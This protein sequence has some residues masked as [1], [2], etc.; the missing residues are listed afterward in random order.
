MLILIPGSALGYHKKSYHFRISNL[1]E[2]IEEF[3][4]SLDLL[5][6]FT[7]EFFEKYPP[8]EDESVSELEKQ[9]LNEG[10]S[11]EEVKKQIKVYKSKKRS[12]AD[13]NSNELVFLSLIKRHT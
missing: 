12:L 11:K 13:I 6:K 4:K 9:E 8:E 10:P 5:E 3:D 1:F 7:K 2:N